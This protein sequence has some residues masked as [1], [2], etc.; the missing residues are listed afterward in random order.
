MTLEELNHLPEEE[1]YFEFEKCCGASAWAI[2]MVNARPFADRDSLMKT[3]EEVWATSGEADWL[4]AFEH[5]PKIGDVE[6]LKEKFA[7]TSAWAGSEQKG[8][9]SATEEVIQKLAEG[10][11]AYEEKFGFIFIVCAT[12]KSAGEMLHLLEQRMV[13]SRK[14]ELQIAAAEQAKITSLRLNK[15]L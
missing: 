3:S 4:E 15:L 11:R 6:S 9:Q 14:E 13:N 2:E 12:G 7:S 5:H 10:N 1:A 8:V